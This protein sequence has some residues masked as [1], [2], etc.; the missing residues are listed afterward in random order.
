MFK[1][2]MIKLKNKRGEE[3]MNRNELKASLIKSSK[4]IVNKNAFYRLKTENAIEKNLVI[5]KSD[6]KNFFVRRK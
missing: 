2:L 1:N 5:N 6:N 4:G 3:H